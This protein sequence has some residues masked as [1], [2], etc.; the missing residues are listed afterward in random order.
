VE[1]F[2]L[3]GRGRLVEGSH[4]D[5]VVVDMKREYKVDSSKFSS[6]AK[7]SPFEGWRVRGKPVK[8]FVGGRVVIDEGEIV[9]KPGTGRVVR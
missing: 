3:K 5:L 6:K 1:I 2:G 9:A 4:A 7:Y 8:T